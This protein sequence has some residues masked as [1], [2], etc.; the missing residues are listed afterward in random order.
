MLPLLP[1]AFVAIVVAGQVVDVLAGVS[2]VAQ[3]PF[4]WAQ[5]SDLA[6]L[7]GGESVV[8]ELALDLVLLV[9]TSLVLRWL[10]RRWVVAQP[11]DPP[12]AR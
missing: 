4:G 5:W 9:V 11:P 2:A 7:G 10:V 8:L 12:R 6:A 1:I 3:L